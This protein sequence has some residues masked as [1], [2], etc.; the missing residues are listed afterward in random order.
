MSD[1]FI[2]PMTE[3]EDRLSQ[4]LRRHE[5]RQYG[6][7][8]MGYRVHQTGEKTFEVYRHPAGLTTANLIAWAS[9]TT[10]AGP[11]DS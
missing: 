9:R 4:A 6:I 7:I 11:R 5:S 3:E 1:N 2:G 8:G 10:P